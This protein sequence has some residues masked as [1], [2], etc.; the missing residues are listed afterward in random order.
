[1]GLCLLDLNSMEMRDKVLQQGY[2]Q[3][4]KKPFIVKPWH[5]DF[6]KEKIEFVPVW[7]NCQNWS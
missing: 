4:Y 1:M 6:Q 5:K 7:Y 3:L 2:Y